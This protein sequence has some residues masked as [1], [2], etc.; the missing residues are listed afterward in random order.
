M[1]DSSPFVY[2]IFLLRCWQESTGVNG[3]A[4]RRFSLE[5]PATGRRHGFAGT[6]DLIEFLERAVEQEGDGAP[7][8]FVDKIVSE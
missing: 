5:D 4:A 8:T 6:V 3:L 7:P 2:R 1:A